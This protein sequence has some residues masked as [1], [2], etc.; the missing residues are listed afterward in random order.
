M[1]KRIITACLM[2]FGMAS[3]TTT[4]PTACYYAKDISDTGI[5]RYTDEEGKKHRFTPFILA[6]EDQEEF[7]VWMDSR[8][9]AAI[10]SDRT[11][12]I[13]TAHGVDSLPNVPDCKKGR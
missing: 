9:H 3:A 1:K 8:K 13:K 7:G 12:W 6:E 2:A 10:N 11:V 5:I 4:K